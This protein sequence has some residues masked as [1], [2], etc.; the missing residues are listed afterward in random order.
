MVEHLREE[1]SLGLNMLS[2][3]PNMTSHTQLKLK[4]QNETILFC[5]HIL[6]RPLIKEKIHFLASKTLIFTLLE[7]QNFGRTAVS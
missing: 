4:M 7:R 1:Y 5:K 2:G 3:V 6:S